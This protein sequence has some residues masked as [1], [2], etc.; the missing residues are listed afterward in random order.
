MASYMLR[1]LWALV[2]CL[3]PSVAARANV[4][5]DWVPR[6]QIGQ[7]GLQSIGELVFTDTAVAK[8]FLFVF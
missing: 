4:I 2:L 5:Y 1:S 8:R 3:V 7:V 6:S